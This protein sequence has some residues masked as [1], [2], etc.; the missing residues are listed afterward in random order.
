METTNT[1]GNQQQDN[2]TAAGAGS[3]AQQQEKTFTQEDVNR[4]VGERL[5]RARLDTSPELQERERKC[6]QRELQLDARE[7]LADAGLPKELLGVINCS[8]KE[9][10][11]NSIKTIQKLFGRT[12]ENS[13]YRVL[14]CGSAGSNSNGSGH[15]SGTDDPESIRKAMGLKG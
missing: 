8:T 5:A 15:R 3:G 9:E 7:K 10:L 13:S 14:M 12:K 2:S 4:I 1:A 11:E 6:M